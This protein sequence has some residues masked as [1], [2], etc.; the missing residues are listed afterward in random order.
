MAANDPEVIADHLQ[1]QRD[2]APA[3]LQHYFLTFEDYWERKL[4]H[5]LTDVLVEF[6]NKPESASQ[7]LPLF[8]TFVVSFS[9]KISQLRLVIIGLLAA[10]QCSCKKAMDGRIPRTFTNPSPAEDER[11]AFLTDL[12]Q[13]VNKPSSQEAF[14]YAQVA[15]ASA[16]LQKD[17]EEGA[18]KDLVQCESILDNFDSVETSVHAAFYRVYGD[19]YQA[20]EGNTESA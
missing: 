3:Y 7:R 2:D 11:L 12:A 13:R 18:Q 4:W 1:T 5:E 6:F 19:Y 15:V 20:R 9:E 8:K 14:V 16:K 10:S 17:D